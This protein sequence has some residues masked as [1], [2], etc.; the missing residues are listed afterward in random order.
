MGKLVYTYGIMGAGKTTLV[1][2]H[3]YNLSKCGRKI[4]VVK[5]GSDTKAGEQI[6]SRQCGRRDVDIILLPNDNLVDRVNLSEYNDIIVD[7]SQFLTR[8]QVIEL[9]VISKKTNINVLC[10]G[11]STNFMAE[12]FDG[13][14]ALFA[15]ADEK[16]EIKRSC[17]ICGDTAVFNARKVDGKFVLVGDSIAIDGENNTEYVSMCGK[18]YL[19]LLMSKEKDVQYVIK[20]L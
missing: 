16:N 2:Q 7:E 4:L 8:K 3:A 19:E 9:W 12:F 20:K 13:S 10:Y 5:P 18:H 11:L 1:L 15:F 14:E 17:E 6:E